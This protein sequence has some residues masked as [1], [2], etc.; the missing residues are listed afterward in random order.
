MK[1]MKR[2][3]SLLL[4]LCLC[5][6]MIP[7]R[8][9]A[10]STI[11]SP[12]GAKG[13]DYSTA[14]ASKLD[15]IFQGRVPLFTSTSSTFALGQSID[16]SEWYT[17]GGALKGKQCYIYSQAVYYYL[18]GDI[19]YHGNGLGAAYWKDSKMILSNRSS[20]S[21]SSFKNAGV[22][23]GAYIRTTSNS[24]GSFNAGVGH[25]MIVLEYDTNGITYLAGN[26]NGSGLI[27]ITTETWSEFNT[28]QLYNKGRRICHVV[29]C[30]SA[31]RGPNKVNLAVDKT[32]GSVGEE[33]TF[34]ASSD[35][36]CEYTL[37]VQNVDTGA[38][39][40]QK[41][42][43]SETCQKTFAAPGHYSAQV[44]ATN[45]K[46]SLTSAAV[47]FWVFGS[48]PKT[49]ALSVSKNTLTLGETVT[50]SAATDADYALFAVELLLY[51]DNHNGT[52]VL[53]GELDESVSFKPTENG[54][55]KGRVTA[56]THEASVTSDW[57]EFYVG[58]Y[59]VKYDANG[60]SGAPAS[61]AKY[62]GKSVALS[63][64][65]P[66][67]TNYSFL[68]WAA[69]A[70]AAKAEYQPGA[71]YTKNADLTLYAVWK[72][73]C[74]EGHSYSYKVTKAPTDA[75]AGKLTGT[76]V[77]CSG[78]TGVTLPKLTSE[79]YS[80][81]V[82]EAATCSTPGI[83]C[84]SWKNTAYGSFSFD[85]EIPV[86]GH[87][88]SA[89]VT[90]PTC[91]ESGYTTY[92]D[93]CGNSYVDRY[94]EALGHDFADGICARCG[95]HSFAYGNAA[96]GE[97]DGL[98][99]AIDE[100]GVLTVSGQVEIADYA[101]ESEMPW[102]EHLDKVT[103]VVIEEGITAIGDY[104]FCGMT[105]LESVEIPSTVTRIG[106]YAFYGCTELVE[107]TIPGSVTEIGELCFSESTVTWIAE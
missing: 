66:I 46:G 11:T 78:T 50:L 89:V 17:V 14:Y 76:C 34:T 93:C 99:W 55:Y 43:V 10:K 91:T 24:D 29:Q 100:E 49:A 61:Q 90:A 44:T 105:K 103:R 35:A 21:Y 32:Q 51:N 80:Y 87:S 97:I 75:A 69:T 31:D 1:Q 85:V 81:A 74:A 20:A 60:G 71:V 41:E 19:V 104:A 79:E 13:S 65:K 70:G 26:A 106:D 83:G 58:K 15:D 72:H 98:N 62:Y 9:E 82:V 48:A 56:R 107:I 37:F 42:T 101:C 33:F 3:C 47:E 8:A 7:V 6:S 73:I 94:T 59:T 36:L 4:V 67:R 92:I 28:S 84:Y 96:S 88:I 53:S 95:R 77:R 63:T 68:G 102:F 86:M 22:G 54:V 25:S 40:I 38:Y 45:N 57:V 39:V 52:K 2:W 16:N 27:R 5:M 64:A 23:F 12:N 18:F 30:N